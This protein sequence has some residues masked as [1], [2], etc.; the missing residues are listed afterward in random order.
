MNVTTTQQ[1]TGTHWV[2]PYHVEEREGEG[3]GGGG[4]ELGGILDWVKRVTNLS[5]PM[6]DVCCEV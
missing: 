4:G 5:L 6:R 2:S 3:E 1:F